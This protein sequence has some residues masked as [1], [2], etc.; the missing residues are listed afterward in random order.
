MGKDVNQQCVLAVLVVFFNIESHFFVSVSLR[1]FSP[2]VFF[3]LS[4]TREPV[5]RLFLCSIAGCRMYAYLYFV[6]FGVL[7][8]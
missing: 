7:L 1:S 5:H 8:R 2:F 3:P 6:Q 4:P